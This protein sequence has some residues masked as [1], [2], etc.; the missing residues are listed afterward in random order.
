[1]R[2]FLSHGSL[3]TIIA[4]FVLVVFIGCS[5]ESVNNN[6][7]MDSALPS[8]FLSIQP[9]QLDSIYNNK[10]IKV[11]AQ[12]LFISVDRDILYDGPLKHIKTRGNSTFAKE[13]KPYTIKFF[14]KQSL[15]G[16]DKS[17]SFVL[18]AN[19]MDE[20]HIRNAIAFDLAHLLGLP[21]PKYTYLSLFVNDEYK[22]LYQMTNKVE[23]G[24]HTLNLID[25]EKLNE[26]AND[27]PLDEY[28]SFCQKD[29]IQSIQCKGMQLEDLPEDISGGYLI[30]L[31]QYYDA[32]TISGFKSSN[33]EWI[34]IDSPKHA[35]KEEVN[36]IE[37]I[38]DTMVKAMN[39][40]SGK[41]IA[42]YIDVHSFV[43]YYLLQEV[44]QNVDGC[45]SSFY[46]YKDQGDSLFY[47]GPVWDFDLSINNV[48]AYGNYFSPNEL[49]VR[50]WPGELSSDADIL[51]NYL[52]QNPSFQE[53]VVDVYLKIFSPV[54]HNYLESGKIESLVS[55]I[56]NEVERDE[57]LYHN[58]I[59]PSYDVALSRVTSFLE[60]RLA[61]L[62]WYYQSDSSDMVC[63]MDVTDGTCPR[64]LFYPVGKPLNLPE[65]YYVEG[66]SNHSPV[67]TWYY[68]GSDSVIKERTPLYKDCSIELRW[69]EPTWW[70]VQFRRIR[71][72]LI[73]W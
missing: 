50:R 23:V 68:A 8:L 66:Y 1:M 67:A 7:R 12:A 27:L 69:R 53:Y 32:R 49:S 72:K 59:D 3:I 20:S 62:D 37:H 57:R 70:E 48:C 18:L 25:L 5:C 6:Q 15:L 36:Y 61:F 19:A 17:K 28:S 4:F 13:K 40:S 43:L 60:Q 56:S 41:T 21:A 38:F 29:E 73:I 35:S 2:S 24:K 54:F 65:P 58:R 30:E 10:D 45:I 22:G 16:L 9:D 52:K 33:G 44:L 31:L 55:Q 64:C 39:P 14:K 63:V 51:F 34:N 46:M 42:E 26:E 47:A 71:K 11:P